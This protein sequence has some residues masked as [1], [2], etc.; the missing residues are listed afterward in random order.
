MS[1]T[2]PTVIAPEIQQLDAANR[3]ALKEKARSSNTAMALM[4]AN[5]VRDQRL[6][7]SAGKAQVGPITKDELPMLWFVLGIVAVLVVVAVVKDSADSAVPRR[8]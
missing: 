5:S 1:S 7:G 6:A 2:E 4:K 8:P 3:S